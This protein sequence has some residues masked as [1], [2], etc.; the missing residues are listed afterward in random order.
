MIPRLYE[1]TAT[2]WG[3]YGICPLI[4]AT[5]CLVT[6]ERN[7]IF[8]LDMEYPRNGRW[9][10]EI[11]VDRIILADPHDGASHAQPFRITEVIFDL[12]GSMSIHAEHISYQLNQVM[13]GH[14]AF[15]MSTASAMWS[16]LNA[17]RA[18]G[19]NGFSF[20][21]DVNALSGSVTYNVDTPKSFRSF[22]GGDDAGTMLDFF[23]G[24]LE[25]DRNT[26]KLLKARGADH[27]VKIAY[28]KNLTGL[29]YDIDMSG[30]VSSVLAYWKKDTAYVQNAQAISN[31]YAFNHF[32]VV[33]A[34]SEF[35]TQ[36]TTTQLRDWA[37]AWLAENA[38]EP[39]LSVEVQFIPL[40]QTEEYKDFYGLEH[41]ALCDTVEV[42]YPPLNIDVKAKVVRTVYDVLRDRYS[43]M[44][45]ST[46]K[47]SLADTIYQLMKG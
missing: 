34:S 38:S 20:T 30:C 31:T 36:P 15:T 5:S 41:V 43:E 28:S 44:S 27:G 9:A 25:W 45:I 6:E 3:N 2:S 39:T 26:V 22:I 35:E 16:G 8:E 14:G 12:T 1:K 40:W 23:G 32:A 7:N 11:I 29:T 4:D 10:D 21:S 37:Q 19:T 18:A 33:D 46:I 24:E 13:V 17:L 42:I 47:Q